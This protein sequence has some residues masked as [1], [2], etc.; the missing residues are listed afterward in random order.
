[1]VD[2]HGDVLGREGDALRVGGGEMNPLEIAAAEAERWAS[3]LTG[4]DIPERC[5]DLYWIVSPT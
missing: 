4:L 3:E 2:E 5:G 1:M